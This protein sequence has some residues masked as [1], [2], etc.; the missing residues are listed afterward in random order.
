MRAI[1]KV[2]PGVTR[3]DG[4][5][6]LQSPYRSLR[7]SQVVSAARFEQNNIEV[8]VLTA[9]VEQIA[10]AS[11]VSAFAFSFASKEDPAAQWHRSARCPLHPSLGTAP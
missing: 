8:Y 9:R 1:Y 5:A 10:H 3:M 6:V 4:K 11:A 7:Q 2:V